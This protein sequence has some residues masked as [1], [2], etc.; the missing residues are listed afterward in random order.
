MNRAQR[1]NAARQGAEHLRT[2]A[3]KTDAEIEKQI[4]IYAKEAQES[5]VNQ[6]QGLM[7][8]IFALVLIKIL[9][10]GPVR[11]FRIL[12]EVAAILNDMANDIITIHDIAR[13]TED[14]G[15]KV[16]F[17]ASY[18]IIECGVFEEDGKREKEKIEEERR[19]LKEQNQRLK[20]ERIWTDPGFDPETVKMIKE[21]Y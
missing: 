13:E 15:I 9:H 17:D 14:A 3:H 12:D 18:N 6:Y 21:K 4:R 7:Y 2:A 1:R 20:G 8:S 5:A 19:I 11:T 10:F 16:V